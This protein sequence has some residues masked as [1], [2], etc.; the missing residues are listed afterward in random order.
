M[1]TKRIPAG[2][3]VHKT[4]Q[5]IIFG[6]QNTQKTLTVEI[7]YQVRGSSQS[8]TKNRTYDVLV[9]SSPINLTVSSFK[10]ITSGQEFDLKVDIKSNSSDT[11]KNVLV[12]AAY[13]FG[14]TYISSSIKPLPD[15]ATWR[16]GDIPPGG[17]KVITIHG[18]LEG[19][20]QDARVFRVSVG[21]QSSRNQNVI[22]TEYTSAVSIK[23]M[24]WSYALAMM[25]PAVGASVCD[26]N[27]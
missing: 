16:I 4:V 1:N 8:F 19:E 24:P 27:M 2:G 3:S 26:P 15:N 22:G 9:N 21:A 20:N 10:E 13:P 7:T 23:L 17:E 18:K 25:R 11:L 6:E 14:F 12:A 5:V